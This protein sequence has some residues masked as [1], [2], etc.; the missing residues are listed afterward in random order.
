VYGDRIFVTAVD[1][2]EKRLET[3]AVARATGKVL[4]RHSVAP[5]RLEQVHEV[6]NHAATTVVADGKRAYVYFGSY[7]LLAY[8]WDGKLAWEKKLPVS[9]AAFG[10]G[11]SP[12]VAADLIIVNRDYNPAPQLLAFSKTNGETV[13]SAS[14]PILKEPGPETSHATPVVWKNQVLLHRPGELSAY[15]LKDG[16]RQWWVRLG[17][18]GSSTPA[19]SGDHVY[20]NA[21]TIGEDSLEPVPLPPFSELLRRFDGNGDG[22]LSR[23]EFPADFNVMR[24]PN[25]P[26]ET[27]AHM[28]AR[29][30]F[31]LID[32]NQDG[33]VTEDELAGVV[34]LFKKF[35]SKL[36][37]VTAIK[38]G[39]EG[40]VTA[41]HVLWRESR[42]VPEIPSPLAYGSRVYGI[43][44][45]GI[46]TCFDSSTG[47][48]LYRSRIGAPGPYFSAPVA[49][50]GRVYTASSEGVITVLKAGDTLQV[51]AK[52]DLG[53]PIF[54]TPALSGTV[55]Y[56]RSA[57]HLWA[58]TTASRPR[59]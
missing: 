20:V 41:S 24:R 49:A 47:K 32:Q 2:K 48:V 3:I 50:A 1:R 52:N 35:I 15:S 33:G 26:L 31:G 29:S 6:N 39:G 25:I 51:L 59:E 56:V 43:M 45:G 22:K 16:A 4:W 58:F 46:L 38:A 17:S 53:E 9:G 55:L 11:G 30:F 12:V 36:H 54:A 44:N 10:A 19:V 37:G 57:G 40:D 23:D 8:E 14:L 7:G 34:P 27:P 18:Q 28:T 5:E 13:W 42:N 21:F